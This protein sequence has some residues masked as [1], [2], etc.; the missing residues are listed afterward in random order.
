M[1]QLPGSTSNS[2]AVCN[3]L[4]LVFCQKQANTFTNSTAHNSEYRDLF[5]EP[6]WARALA[7]AVV[8]WQRRQHRGLFGC[9]LD[10]L[11]VQIFLGQPAHLV[12]H[13]ICRLRQ[14]FVCS[15]YWLHGHANYQSYQIDTARQT[16]RSLMRYFVGAFQ[17]PQ[18][19]RWSK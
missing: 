18:G 17:I 16:G 14:C 8:R 19:L 12:L 11:E 2:V 13:Q 1:V 9:L 7:S 15:C 5:P 3:H 4:K 6:P 10:A